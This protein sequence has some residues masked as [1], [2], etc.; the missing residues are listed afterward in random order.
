MALTKAERN[1]IEEHFESLRREIVK[2]QIDVA[3]LKARG[4]FYG[5]IGGMIPIIILICV[6]LITKWG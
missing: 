5:L 4:G 3:T 6:Y 1:W 2:V